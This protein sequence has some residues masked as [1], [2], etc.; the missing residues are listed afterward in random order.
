[1]RDSFD[2]GDWFVGDTTRFRLE[3]AEI[4]QL[5]DVLGAAQNER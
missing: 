3:R 2:I 5:R 1:M 4:Q